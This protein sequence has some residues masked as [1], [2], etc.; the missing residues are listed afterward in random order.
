MI[1]K[2]LLRFER[3]FYDLKKCFWNFKEFQHRIFLENASFSKKRPLRGNAHTAKYI[4]ALFSKQKAP[5]GK[6]THGEMF[7][8]DF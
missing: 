2:D 3:I 6:F 8:N 1:L 7:F 4:L 5:A